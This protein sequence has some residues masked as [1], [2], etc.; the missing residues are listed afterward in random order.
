VPL[1]ITALTLELGRLGAALPEDGSIEV[2][3]VHVIGS[4]V[5]VKD[6]RTV[7]LMLT[8][9]GGAQL[10]LE[11]GKAELEKMRGQIDEAVRLPPTRH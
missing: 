1:A 11:L 6:N 10:P 8:L 9:K 4:E 3:G 5:A 2:Q 7:V